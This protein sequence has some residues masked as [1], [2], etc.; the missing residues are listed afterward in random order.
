[1][2]T[3]L[4]RTFVAAMSISCNPVVTE[5]GKNPP[6]IIIILADDLGYADVSWNNANAYAETPNLDKLAKQ[7][8]ILTNCYSASSM[9]SPS[10]AGLLTGRVPTRVGVHDWIK[11]IYKKP[12]SDF[13]LPT[14]EI[15][16]AEL[17]KKKNYQ[18]AV[19][20]KWHLNNEFG[21]Q[22]QSDPDDQGFDYWFCTP[23][24]A[25]PT[26]K[27]PVNFYDNGK[28]VGQ[29]GTE[30]NPDFASR[31]VADK[32]IEWLNNKHTGLPF[33]LYIPFHEPHVICDAPE[34]IKQKYIDRIKNGE[35][36][37][38][39]GTGVGGLGQAEYY[40]CIENMDLAIGRILEKLK[41]DRLMEN[42][43]IIFTSDNGPDT[44]R[45]YQ[46]RIQSVGETGEFR[47]RKRWLLE[48]G[49]RQ[50]T[51]IYWNSVLKPGT[52]IDTPV[53]H[54]DLLPTLC[55]IVQIKPPPDR[56][57][58]GSSILSV[59][60]GKSFDRNGKNLH[61]HFHAPWDGPQSVMRKD[62]WVVTANWDKKTPR[63]RFDTTKIEVIK[64]AKLINF[65]LYDLRTDPGEQNDVKSEH[66]QL[67]SDLKQQLIEM[68][69]SVKN[70]CPNS[71]QFQWNSQ[72]QEIVDTKYEAIKEQ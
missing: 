13:H 71:N 56:V 52:K 10:R 3:S 8:A 28:S 27:N 37:F 63:G 5:K 44:N 68:H 21:T 62:N 34:K 57:I 11:E 67:F 53:G 42:T 58:D 23:V 59:L 51:I 39:A 64:T 38:K 69:C 45:K 18:T 55:D 50:A 1:M 12:Y 24:Q 19:I 43:I 65:N 29:I 30:E 26:H 35:I 25:N 7:A 2:R 54:I 40:G 32:T 60:Q 47:G 22:N 66:M 48:G 4:L 49:I 15:T 9:C 6:N 33:M 36:P 41:S 17:L 14:Q 70:E 20:G 31:I 61:W 46:G 16:F 72:L